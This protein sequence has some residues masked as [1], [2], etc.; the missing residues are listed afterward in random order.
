MRNKVDTHRPKG[1]KRWMIRLLLS[2]QDVSDLPANSKD[3]S[4]SEKRFRGT[5]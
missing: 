4:L 5:E 2:D 1:T 3:L